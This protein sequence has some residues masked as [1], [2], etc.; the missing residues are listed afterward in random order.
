[1]DFK[2]AMRSW[3]LP[4]PGSTG[5]CAPE[6]LIEQMIVSIWCGMARFAHADS[7]A[8]IRRDTVVWLGP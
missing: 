2:A 5:G 1:V 3:N 8:W 6:Q 4:K 7:L